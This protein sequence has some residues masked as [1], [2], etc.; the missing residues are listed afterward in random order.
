[1]FVCVDR[2][3]KAGQ[4]KRLASQGASGT[5]QARRDRTIPNP[6]LLVD[7]CVPRFET[8]S[9]SHSAASSSSVRSSGPCVSSCCCL[10]YANATSPTSTAVYAALVSAPAAWKIAASGV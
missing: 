8:H 3:G 5:R 10:A 2:Q 7:V 9:A 4:W 1:M 6:S